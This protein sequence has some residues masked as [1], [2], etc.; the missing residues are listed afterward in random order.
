[1]RAMLPNP[2]LTLRIDPAHVPS[3]MSSRT[4]ISVVGISVP[5]RSYVPYR[6]SPSTLQPV[7]L[8]DVLLHRVR[9]LSPED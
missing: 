7:A 9:L 2:D 6:I 5:S 8:P 1:M 4:T 3:M